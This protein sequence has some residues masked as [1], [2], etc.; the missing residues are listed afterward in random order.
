MSGLLS[1]HLAWPSGKPHYILG[2]FLLAIQ[3]VTIQEL[4]SLELG[5]TFLWC[6]SFPSE[7]LVCVCVH[8]CKYLKAKREHQILHL[9]LGAVN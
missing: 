9:G 2:P 4:N 8:V 3:K 7:F 6:L 5:G 1:I